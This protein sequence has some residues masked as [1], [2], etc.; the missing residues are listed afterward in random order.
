MRL[1]TGII[2]DYCDEF[3]YV[4]P[5]QACAIA[6]NLQWYVYKTSSSNSNLILQQRSKIF[7]H[8]SFLQNKNSNSVIFYRQ[9]SSLLENI[10]A[11][12]FVL[13]AYYCPYNCEMNFITVQWGSPGITHSNSV[14]ISHNKKQKRP[15]WTQVIKLSLSVNSAI[16][17]PPS[18]VKATSFLDCWTK[19][20]H[21][22]CSAGFRWWGAW[23]PG[24]VG[25][26]M[27]GYR[28]FR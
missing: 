20:S 16:A 10:G 6:P 25:G 4:F 1:H 17:P 5:H 14:E 7:H 2:E 21:D 26:S 3:I 18:C 13:Y 23:D 12:N 9:G 24:V 19:Q 15:K 28:I 22:H 8:L 27:C 11:T